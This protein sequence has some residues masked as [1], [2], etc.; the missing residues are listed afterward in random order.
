L[1]II[2]V[3]STNPTTLGGTDGTI[4]ITFS[5]P[6]NPSTYTLNGVPKGAVVSP[7]VVTGLSA[8]IE[9]TVA[10]TDSAACTKQSVITLG[11]SATLFDADWIMATYQF[12]D[13][14]DLDTR[15]R[16]VTPDIGQDT[17]PEYLGWGC[18][19]GI[20]LVNP[21]IPY[22]EGGAATP[23][24]YILLFG[25]D[26]TGNGFE[27]ILVNIQRL[28]AQLP[29]TTEFV[30][31]LRSFWFTTTGV[32]PVIAAVTL[33]KGGTPIHDGCVVSFSAP[34]CWTNP[35]ADF[36]GTIDSVPKVITLH[37]PDHAA[38]QASSGERVATLRYN[39]NT[40]IAVLDNADVTTPSV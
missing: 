34:F 19:G 38:K 36:T 39:L 10:I 31:D 6:S 25:N 30:L 14:I 9:Y 16:M 20:D 17:Q 8:E 5:T 27:S 26:N 32:Q 33:W 40:F 29:Q 3:T 12:T 2:L 21:F 24:E 4:T 11:Q 28:K 22:T 1:E 7:L 13:G 18:Q 23:S 35:T 37:P 15:T